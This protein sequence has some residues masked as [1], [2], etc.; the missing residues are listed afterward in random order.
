MGYYTSNI[1]ISNSLVRKCSLKPEMLSF[2]K[3]LLHEVSLEYVF[4]NHIP[5]K[6]ILISLEDS[7]TANDCNS[8]HYYKHDETSGDKV[9]ITRKEEETQLENV[10][11]TSSDVSTAVGDKQFPVIIP[12]GGK[13]LTIFACSN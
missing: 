5:Y 8:S 6:D 12:I 9:I 4:V 3:E 13:S 11:N 2:W 10:L 7:S 1:V